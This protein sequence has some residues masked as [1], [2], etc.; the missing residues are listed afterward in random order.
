[1]IRIWG[2]DKMANPV[3]FALRPLIAAADQLEA[4]LMRLVNPPHRP[5][6]CGFIFA[7]T[8]ALYTVLARRAAR[9]LRKVMPDAQIDI[10]TD[11]DFSDPTFSQIH[12]LGDSHARPKM[13]AL[14][15][16]RFEKTVYLDADIVVLADLSELFALLDK[17][18][19]AACQGW[20]RGEVYLGEGIMPRA[21]PMLNSGVLAIRRSRNSRAFLKEWENRVKSTN[22]SLDQGMLRQ[23]L[24][25]SNLPFLVLPLEYNM[26][27][28]GLLGVWENKMGAP[29]V[30]HFKKLHNGDPGNPEE[31]LDAMALL[32]PNR[33]SRLAELIEN[34][35][36]FGRGPFST[37]AAATATGGSRWQRALRRMLGHWGGLI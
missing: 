31:P 22:A 12:R 28:I 27:F 35:S 7:T 33:A 18:D 13:E 4:G 26:I 11:Q 24:Y 2:A 9:T 37:R 6:D 23:L 19:L 5:H 25:D 17:A 29:R 1:M 14:R 15:R 34:D 20:G 10:F 30:L 3:A 16:S 8:G 36:S 32:G 21:F